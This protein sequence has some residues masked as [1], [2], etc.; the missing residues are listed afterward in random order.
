MPVR[1]S[2]LLDQIYEKLCSEHP[3]D[4]L[5]EVDELSVLLNDALESTFQCDMNSFYNTLVQVRQRLE[6][7][8]FMRMMYEHDIE[9]FNFASVPV[10]L[11][12]DY[13][14]SIY[15]IQCLIA[16]IEYDIACCLKDPMKKVIAEY[17]RPAVYIPRK[18]SGL[19]LFEVEDEE[20]DKRRFSRKRT[21]K[22][23]FEELEEVLFI[24]SLWMKEYPEIISECEQIETLLAD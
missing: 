1:V 9:F 4:L 14:F 19:G 22:D 5:S 8:Q 15:R 11:V 2:F 10:Y 23:L 6:G 13:R 18:H 16:S 24:Y 21:N 7:M 17:L 3:E 20:A 12:D